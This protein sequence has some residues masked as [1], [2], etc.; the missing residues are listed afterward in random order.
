MKNLH[1]VGT[2]HATKREFDGN[3]VKVTETW[4]KM[5]RVLTIIRGCK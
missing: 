3:H 2:K 4:K 5:T 1:A